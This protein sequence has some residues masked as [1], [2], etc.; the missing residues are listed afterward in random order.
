[1]DT[2]IEYKVCDCLDRQFDWR[3]K[4]NAGEGAGSSDAAEPM[5]EGER[6]V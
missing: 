3:I 1:M 4:Q 5:T 2:F 6:H